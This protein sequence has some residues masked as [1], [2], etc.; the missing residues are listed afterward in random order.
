[1]K[2]KMNVKKEDV[3]DPFIDFEK[4]MH[5]SID[6]RNQAILF[7]LIA[8]ALLIVFS[9]GIMTCMT[10][11]CPMTYPFGTGCVVFSSFVTLATMFGA[12]TGCILIIIG[13]G[14]T[15]SYS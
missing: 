11:A 4:R 10:S 8:G 14:M 12:V 5:Q 9:Y 3:I 13:L 1:M 2:R 6:A 15:V 7:C